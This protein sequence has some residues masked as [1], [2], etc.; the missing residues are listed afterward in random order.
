MACGR[1][2]PT[3]KA[4]KGWTWIGV[5]DLE[6][7][8]G[9]CGACGKQEIRYIH[10]LTHHE[11]PSITVGCVCAGN[12][13]EDYVN[14]AAREKELRAKARA[15]VN[16][17]KRYCGYYNNIP[18]IP[19]PPGLEGG[20]AKV[21]GGW[22]KVKKLNHKWVADYTLIPVRSSCVPKTRSAFIDAKSFVEAAHKAV[23]QFG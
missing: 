5:D 18:W 4:H 11:H 23:W 21:A 14:P 8:T 16:E 22:L 13:T 17:R 6:D 7:I 3:L 10:F 20:C 9:E 1:Y 2:L 12:L 15:K 19:L